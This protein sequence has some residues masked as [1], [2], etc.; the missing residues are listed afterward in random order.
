VSD[1]TIATVSIER[2][3][4]AFI[5][6][7]FR[8]YQNDGDWAPPLRGEALGPRHL[9]LDLRFVRGTLSSIG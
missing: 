6:L 8:P 4:K 5:D 1:P 2:Q 3:R 9:L 7:P